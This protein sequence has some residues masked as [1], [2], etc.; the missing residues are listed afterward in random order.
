MKA[1]I[2]KKTYNT[3]T[4]KQLGSKCVG[5]FGQPYGYEE[6]LFVTK[7]GLHFLYGTGGADSPYV[8]ETITALT[9]DEAACWKKENGI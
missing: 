2:N 4:S 8:E 1:I 5:E 3:D 9:D 7:S 6:Q